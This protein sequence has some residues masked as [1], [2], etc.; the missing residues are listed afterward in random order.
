MA[1]LDDKLIEAEAAY[2]E[3]MLGR[4]VARIKDANGEEVWYNAANAP[5]L[6]AYI[7]SLKVQIAAIGTTAR[8]TGPLRPYF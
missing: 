8:C 6:A 2:H 1:A 7:A 4:G 3:V 5:R